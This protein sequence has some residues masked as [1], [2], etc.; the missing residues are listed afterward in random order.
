MLN[1]CAALANLFVSKPSL[2]LTKRESLRVAQVS[3]QGTLKRTPKGEERWRREEST[4]DLKGTWIAIAC[5]MP[6]T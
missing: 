6:Y 5:L 3:T 1:I 4:R 2:D